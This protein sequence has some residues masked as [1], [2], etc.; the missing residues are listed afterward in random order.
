MKTK[1]EARY[2]EYPK[3]AQRC[4]KCTMFRAPDKCTLVQGKISPAGWS[5]YFERKDEV[6]PQ[7]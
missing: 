4:D 6:G 3:G 1:S 5:K 7:H 2:Q